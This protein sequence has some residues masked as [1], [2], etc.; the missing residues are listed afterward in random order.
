MITINV[1]QL[2][3][4]GR[5]VRAGC[6][7]D[8]EAYLSHLVDRLSQGPANDIFA[9][10]HQ[11]LGHRRRKPYQPDPLPIIKGADGA[12]CE[13]APDMHARWRQHFGDLE[14]GQAVLLDD[15]AS[16]FLPEHPHAVSVW[17]QPDDVGLV[18]TFGALQRVLASTKCAKAPGFDKIP[19]ELCKHFSA[20]SAHL[21]LPLLLKHVWRGCEALGWKGG[22][23][24]YFYK[25][26][27][28]VQEC[29]SYRAVLLLSAFLPRLATRH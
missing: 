14:G 25:Q 22:Q 17:P 29:S 26:K 13:N 24:I 5:A 15:L 2:G 16:A 27:G 10:Y 18:P 8:R 7:R 3:V 23:S 6:R 12:L 20:E 11:V 4:Y 21:L 28:S 9:A 19:P 1:Q